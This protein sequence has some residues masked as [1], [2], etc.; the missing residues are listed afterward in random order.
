[1]IAVP[2]SK[3]T[4]LPARIA[5]ILKDE[6]KRAERFFS[7]PLK[8]RAQK[9]FHFVDLDKHV[10][11]KRIL[12]SEFNGKCAYSESPITPANCT[13]IR[14]RPEGGAIGENGEVERDHYWWLAYEWE[15]LIPVRREIARA[16]GNHFPVI[17]PRGRAGTPIQELRSTETAMIP[18]PSDPKMEF[19]PGHTL[20]GEFI[21]SNEVEN[22]AIKIL[23]LNLF[24]I[25]KERRHAIAAIERLPPLNQK[26]LGG[27]LSEIDEGKDFLGLRCRF[28]LR[29]FREFLEKSPEEARVELG[30]GIISSLHQNLP[31]SHSLLSLENGLQ[32]TKIAA[33]ISEVKISAEP[34]L[35]EP[36]NEAFRPLTL[37]HLH[38]HNFKGIYSL[39]IDFPQ[40]EHLEEGEAPFGLMVLGE[41]GSGKS[42]ILQAIALALEEPEK[43]H[44][45][46]FLAI[47]K[48]LRR[49]T[50]DGFVRLSILDHP[51]PIEV[52]FA[53]GQRKCR[54]SGPRE[55][56]RFF[57]RAYGAHRLLPRYNDDRPL[58]KEP[59]PIT[60]NNLWDPYESL[61]DAEKWILAQKKRFF[62]LFALALKDLL[63]LGNDGKIYTKGKQLRFDIGQRDLALDELSAGYQSV[64]ATATD[65]IAGYPIQGLDMQN[66][67]GVVL[68]DEIGAHLHPS[69][70]MRIV[71]AYRRTFPKI[72]FIST[73]HEPLC[74][75]GV[76]QEELLVLEK[77]NSTIRP[78]ENLP[79]L[80]SMRVDQILTS[81]IFG[82]N[83]TI[84]PDVEE[85][86]QEYYALLR[87]DKPSKKNQ[88]RIDEL[89]THLYRYG[90]LGSSRR[91]RAVYDIIDKNLA[92]GTLDGKGVEITNETRKLVRD[93]W[94]NSD[95]EEFK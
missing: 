71:H 73:T 38:I 66:A 23:G 18:D 81:P 92:I 49:G 10:D 77:K 93:L 31:E 35:L 91:A 90:V 47:P 15:N 2:R 64:I 21:G 25:S 78:I 4:N 80:E 6:A 82:L 43:V 40:K 22:Q 33:H 26:T 85:K 12:V 9:R 67:S 13:I 94:T 41:N 95:L 52:R 83:T 29:R 32:L 59:G 58:P 69:W 63:N 51:E 75:R 89:R 68:I 16:K 8:S 79:E 60:I 86:F 57:F 88:E 42:T 74:L 53:Q 84:D 76:R 1:M 19:H 54:F 28:F 65:I 39:K 46:P 72:Q 7:N 36:G 20:K 37:T 14:H 45:N 87:K 62:D 70:R 11:L 24:D 44:G 34:K 3:I 50:K 5:T 61:I 27:Y 55:S 48:I 30:S 56:L 17:G